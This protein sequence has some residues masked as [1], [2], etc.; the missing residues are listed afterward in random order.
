MTEV[1]S[2]TREYTL[3]EGCPVCESDL[4]VRVTATGP[5]AVCTHCGWMGRPFITVTYDGLRVSYDDA[6]RA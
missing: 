4:P 3:P 1:H 6:A 2:Q 5:N